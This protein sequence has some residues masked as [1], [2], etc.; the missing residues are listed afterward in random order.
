MKIKLVILFLLLQSCS[1]ID[2][3]DIIGNWNGDT[4]YDYFPSYWELKITN[5]YFFAIDN[6]GYID[7]FEYKF[8]NNS[9][10]VINGKT[11]TLLDVKKF[12]SD[13]IQVG[14]RFFNRV[15]NNVSIEDDFYYPIIGIKTNTTAQFLSSN[16]SIVHLWKNAES[17]TKIRVGDKYVKLED[18]K[19]LFV[20][21][22]SKYDTEVAVFIGQN[23]SLEDLKSIHLV[24]LSLNIREITYVLDKKYQ[25]GYSI[26]K[27]KMFYWNKEIDDYLKEQG[28]PPF[29]P[30]T[31]RAYSSKNFKKSNGVIISINSPNDI[32][33]LDI[34]NNG[35][36][37]VEID[38]T[39]A[40][41]E[42]IFIKQKIN[43][44]NEQ[45]DLNIV[46]TIVEV[47]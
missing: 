32:G 12:N 41:E 21:Y 7:K 11:D 18:L 20:V 34:I 3:N 17:E 40:L 27:D 4:N 36:Y 10:N 5:D 30:L 46:G 24:L 9:L 33:L 44:L 22:D 39:L 26:F 13:S 29:P 47:E 37:V 43:E 35:D 23:I 2:K 45:E 42:Y 28:Q 1:D 14:N 31:P 19:S 15:T 25:E 6:Y 8:S 38:T 16:M